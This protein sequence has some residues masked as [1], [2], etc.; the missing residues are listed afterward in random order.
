MSPIFSETIQC[1]HHLHIH[2]SKQNPFLPRKLLNSV[3]MLTLFFYSA[4]RAA[5]SLTFVRYTLKVQCTRVRVCRIVVSVFPIVW[6]EMKLAAGDI[7]VTRGPVTAEL[8]KGRA[9]TIR[10]K[11]Q[12]SR[13]RARSKGTTELLSTA[14]TRG[15]PEVCKYAKTLRGRPRVC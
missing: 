5:D 2:C 12:P 9:Q 13:S 14:E 6:T 7:R 10:N 15:I 4:W 11:E 3:T 8:E 1:P